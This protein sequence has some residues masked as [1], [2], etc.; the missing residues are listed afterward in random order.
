VDFVFLAAWLLV[1]VALILLANALFVREIKAGGIVYRRAE[2]PRSYRFEVAAAAAGTFVTAAL[3]ALLPHRGPSGYPLNPLP[4]LYAGYGLYFVL[5]SLWHGRVR[6][7]GR[8]YL[9]RE[10]PREFWTLVLVACFASLAVASA[11]V[12][13]ALS[14]GLA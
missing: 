6:F 3:L 11:V 12:A 14:Q 8:D 4:V 9:R 13:F 7:A 1:L 10:Q 2:E 5:R